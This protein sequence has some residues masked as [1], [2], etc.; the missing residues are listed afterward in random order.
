MVRQSQVKRE[1]KTEVINLKIVLS[2]LISEFDEDIKKIDEIEV[3]GMITST[4]DLEYELKQLVKEN[5][6]A[7]LLNRY[8]FDDPIDAVKLVK[9]I[10][11]IR[12]TQRFV[13]LT[14][15][16]EPEFIQPLVNIGVYDYLI[17]SF[18]LHEVKEL[19]F[20]PSKEFNFEDEEAKS[21]GRQ[22]SKDRKKINLKLPLTP[23]VMIKSVFKE[24][25]AFVELGDKHNIGFK[26][27]KYLRSKNFKV[28]FLDYDFMDPFA[29]A[30]KSSKNNLHDALELYN[31][32]N[33]IE[34]LE[35]F[36]KIHEKVTVLSAKFNYYN[37]YHLSSDLLSKFI[38]DLKS[39]YDYIVVNVNSYISDR[40]TNVAL[41][42]ADNI[43]LCSSANSEIELEKMNSYG[44]LISE[45]ISKIDGFII[46]NYKG[47]S[48]TSI[49]IEA[50]ASR[51]ILSYIDHKD[52][53]SKKGIRGK[54]ATRSINK[55]F[56]KLGR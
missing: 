15:K 50:A 14:G 11:E 7:I 54:L 21:K 53:Y 27:A 37:Y 30:Y 6:D 32:T 51:N 17:D 43:Y 42:E 26:Y 38:K 31:Q 3:L 9:E 29:E 39:E 13:V 36:T 34:R 46:S 28:L 44:H 40:A 5:P 16:Y 1:R 2:T 35:S 47:D 49:E 20:N 18:E 41:E 22:D 45:R 10:R 52:L 19:L 25:I 56:R 48:L 8:L 23:K 12:G 33:R 55:Q 4:E 24:V